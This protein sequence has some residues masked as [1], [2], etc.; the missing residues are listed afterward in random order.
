MCDWISIEDRVPDSRRWVWVAQ[1]V[2][3]DGV[4]YPRVTLG[5][6]NDGAWQD[7]WDRGSNGKPA[8]L[9]DYEVTHWAEFE[10]PE[11]PEDCGP[12]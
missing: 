7:E 12:C 4:E 8:V 2:E 11:P 3:D 1:W 9:P 6:I 5:S 10:I